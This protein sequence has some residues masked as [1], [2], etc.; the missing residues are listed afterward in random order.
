MLAAVVRHE[1][2]CTQLVDDAH[3]I[4]RSR[5][6]ER[7]NR[8][9]VHDVGGAHDSTRESPL[10]VEFVIRGTMGIQ[11]RSRRRSSRRFHR[12]DCDA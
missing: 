6:H 5:L 1:R 12:S 8:S 9:G 10:D 2:D 3:N 7:G 11:S 4:R